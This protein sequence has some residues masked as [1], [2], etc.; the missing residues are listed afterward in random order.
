MKRP[1]AIAA[2]LLTAVVLGCGSHGEPTRGRRLEGQVLESATYKPLHHSES[3]TL[4]RGAYSQ[5]HETVNLEEV[6]GYGDLNAD[7]VEDA[8]VVLV[9]SGGGSGTFKEIAAVLNHNGV[10]VHVASADLGDRVKVE[11]IAVESGRIR[12]QLIVH[13]KNDPMCCPTK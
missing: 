4:Q 5:G 1:V 10:P 6:R 8:A 2:G 3:V 12:V 7:G 9:R 11:A 13:D